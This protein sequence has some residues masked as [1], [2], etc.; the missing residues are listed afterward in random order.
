VTGYERQIQVWVKG[1]AVTKAGEV[2]IERTSKMRCEKPVSRM[3]KRVGKKLFPRFMRQLLEVLSGDFVS[4]H[5]PDD[6]KVVERGLGLTFRARPV[7]A[8]THRLSLRPYTTASVRELSQ[9]F[10]PNAFRLALGSATDEDLEW[11]RD[12]VRTFVGLMTGIGTI[13]GGRAPLLTLFQDL[14]TKCTTPVG[15]AIFLMLWMVFRQR[16]AALQALQVLRTFAM[17]IPA[18]SDLM[19]DERLARALRSRQA[20]ETFKGAVRERFAEHREEIIVY[21]RRYSEVREAFDYVRV[22]SS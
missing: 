18:M 6:A 5:D 14:D 12:E 1:G 21:L 19:T 7:R 10:S 13:F 8:T 9:S 15:K 2:L 11:A 17:R 16:T 3:R 20:M 4:W 22:S